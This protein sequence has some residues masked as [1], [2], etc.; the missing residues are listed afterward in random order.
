MFK[1]VGALLLL[2]T[3][4]GQRPAQWTLGIVVQP[5]EEGIVVVRVEPGGPA[6][7][8]GLRPGDRIVGLG[9]DHLASR[10]EF[11]RALDR[12]DGETLGVKVHRSVG[13]IEV[14]VPRDPRDP[15][16]RGLETTQRQCASYCLVQE[17]RKWR[18][19]GCVIAECKTCNGCSL[20]R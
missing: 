8:G 13:V 3:T 18:D 10:A 1:A 9:D 5:A 17:T 15:R 12:H 14:L 6:A 4:T 19:C 20:Q 2:L 7:A 11:Q 16:F